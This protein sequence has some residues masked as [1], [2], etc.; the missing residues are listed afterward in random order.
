[1]INGISRNFGRIDTGQHSAAL[2]NWTSRLVQHSWCKVS[3]SSC[4]Y[5]L[6]KEA[7]DGDH[8]AGKNFVAGQFLLVGHDARQSSTTPHLNRRVSGPTI[9]AT[10]TTALNHRQ[11]FAPNSA[12]PREGQTTSAQRA[13][14]SIGH[15]S[16]RV[17]IRVST[18]T[19]LVHPP[20]AVWLC[21][22]RARLYLNR[23]PCHEQAR[24]HAGNRSA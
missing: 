16:H 2:P 10:C 23:R 5:R 13:S 3:S 20:D 19:P 6:A 21:H 8:K 12:R 24:R 1:M 22:S 11:A 18:L 9:R 15:S 17:R 7:G 4:A 14:V